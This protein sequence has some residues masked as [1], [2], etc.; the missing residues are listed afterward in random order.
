MFG[1]YLKIHIIV[2][3]VDAE[4]E[5]IFSKITF[6]LLY[7]YIYIYIY[8]MKYRKITRGRK[9]PYGNSKGKGTS[10]FK[11]RY[12]KMRGG[13]GHED[14][15]VTYPDGA[16]L[17]SCIDAGSKLGGEYSDPSY[18]MDRYEAEV[19]SSI[20]GK[21]SSKSSRQYVVDP[22]PR[23][24]RGSSNG[25]RTEY[26]SKRM[27]MGLFTQSTFYFQRGSLFNIGLIEILKDKPVCNNIST[28]KDAFF[29]GGKDVNV[30]HDNTAYV[31]FGGFA[32]K[33]GPITYEGVKQGLGLC[34]N[35]ENAEGR[36]RLYMGYWYQDKMN[37]LGIEVDF[38]Y[39]SGSGNP[40]TPVGIYFG[41]F[42][43]GKRKGYGIYYNVVDGTE[44]FVFYTGND[45]NQ[46]VT[47]ASYEAGD[48]KK[49]LFET[50]VRTR[51]VMNFVDSTGNFTATPSRNARNVTLK[52][53]LESLRTEFTKFI[54]TMG[55]VMQKMSADDK[56]RAIDAYKPVYTN[57]VNF[58][59]D[60]IYGVVHTAYENVRDKDAI[61][62]KQ[63]DDAEAARKAAR[64]LLTT[65]G[66]VITDTKEGLKKKEE[67]EKCVTMLNA[68]S[69]DVKSPEDKAKEKAEIEAKRLGEYEELQG[70]AATLAEL[71]RQHA[72]MKEMQQSGYNDYDDSRLLAQAVVPLSATLT[73]SGSRRRPPVQSQSQSPV[74]AP[75]KLASSFNAAANDTNPLLASQPRSS[76]SSSR[77]SSRAANGGGKRTRKNMRM[78]TRA[79][80]RMRK[81]R[82][83][84]GQ[85]GVSVV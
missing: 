84:G 72:I 1:V 51:L 79:M 70:K 54:D 16:K 26:V 15:G 52:S 21:G 28:C 45:G 56:L 78:R 59:F 41:H 44:N 37:G 48:E 64:E 57:F 66:V 80:N 32:K 23:M 42:I 29:A 30:I 38:G 71:Q 7:M 9:A 55:G 2:D 10:K 62:K 24:L 17:M 75:L 12:R 76:R 40:I 6:N 5:L 4:V 85:W 60:S 61:A 43:Q 22:L 47:S 81:S 18:D 31:F 36:G 82:R 53:Y 11:T 46:C 8:I 83:G 50:T 14:S 3:I 20:Q 74:M 35:V 27:R 63:L 73:R 77:R 65:E 58:C 39:V 67:I 25:M 34:Y 33:R 19:N 13:Y 49:Q 68:A 69:Y